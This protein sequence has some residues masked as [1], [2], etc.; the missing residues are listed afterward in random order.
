MTSYVQQYAQLHQEYLMYS[1]FL[2]NIFR[3]AV[4]TATLKKVLETS[5]L[6]T[7]ICTV[8]L[9]KVPETSLEFITLLL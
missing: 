9:K 2:K 1:N 8:T 4:F 7:G 3:T 6:C 5:F